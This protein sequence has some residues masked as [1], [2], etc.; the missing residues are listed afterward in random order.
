MPHLV[1]GGYEKSVSRILV[2]QAMSTV[3]LALSIMSRKSAQEFC[4]ALPVINM[5]CISG[6]L[7]IVWLRVQREAGGHPA[8]PGLRPLHGPLY[9]HARPAVLLWQQP[10]WLCRRQGRLRIPRLW[11][12]G[13]GDPGQPAPQILHNP[14][15]VAT[16]NTPCFIEHCICAV[17]PGDED[18]Q[19][20]GFHGRV[21]G[22]MPEKH[23]KRCLSSDL[24]QQGEC[25]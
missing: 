4:K 11:W 20:D 3:R 16:Y 12:H 8:Q 10:Q 13:S 18:L 21:H 9:Q 5:T 25:W 7:S 23:R 2:R 15:H 17:L 24:L 6:A 14:M 22:S 19:Q 1:Q